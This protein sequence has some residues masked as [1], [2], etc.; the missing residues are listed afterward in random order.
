MKRNNTIYRF[1]GTL[2]LAGAV[3]VG[4][5]KATDTL[6]PQSVQKAESEKAGEESQVTTETPAAEGAFT[7][8][9]SADML[10]TKA[11]TDLGQTL[12]S[13]WE[14]G[15]SVSVYNMT[16]EQAIEG[17]LY[18]QADGTSSTF[19]G[20]VSGN[21]NQGDELF[22]EFLE[23][24]Y[25]IQD[26]TLE[27]LAGQS[28]WAVATVK[29]T[30]IDPE[31]KTIAT[32]K[33]AFEKRQAVVKFNITNR[34]NPVEPVKVTTFYAY[35]GIP[36]GDKF[37]I[38]VSPKVASDELYVAIPNYDKMPVTFEA[39]GEDG[40]DYR[41]IVP[42]VNFEDGLYYRR[43]LQMKRRALVKAPVAKTGLKFN[44][45][46]Q[47]LVDAAHVY[48]ISNEQEV[49]LDHE[50]D[51]QQDSCVISYFVKKEETAETVP[52]AP[53]A[54]ENGWLPS[55]PTQM[56]AGT[57]YIWTKMTGNYD[58]EDADV[59]DEP[60]K[61]VLA[62]A[63]AT[64]SATAVSTEM[65]YSG[66]SQN[67]LSAGAKLMM[68][69]NDITSTKDGDNQ[70]PIIKYYV[71]TENLS[72]APAA[73]NSSWGTS[74]AAVHAGTH[75]VWIMTEGNGDINAVSTK[76][77]K[78]IKKATATLTVT[79]NSSTLT[80]NGSNQNLLSGAATLKIGSTNVTSA[81]DAQSKACSIQYYVSTSST[82][83][84]GGSW[85]T[86]SYSA[87]NAGTYYVW[88][89][90]TGN[91]DINDIA[92][93]YKVSKGI[94][95]KNPTFS[96]ASSSVTFGQSDA[97]NSTKTVNITYDGD[98]TLSASSNDAT[99][100]TASISN[101]VLTIT[102]KSGDA[103]TVTITVT[104]A[105][106]A[107]YNA[108]TGK[109]VTVTL[110]ANDTGVALNSALVGYKVASNGKAYA[111][112]ATIPTGY[113]L[114]GVIVKLGVV[115]KAKDQGTMYNREN[116]R[117]EDKHSWAET[118]YDYYIN[119]LNDNATQ[120]NWILGSRQDYQSIFGGDSVNI[121]SIQN[122]L[123]AAGANPLTVGGVGYGV[124]CFKEDKR[125]IVTGDN[126]VDFYDWSGSTAS[127]VRYVRLIFT[128]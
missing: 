23:P 20:T 25:G 81:T 87:K 39:E 117:V 22:L 4:C 17:W 120:K 19:S 43:T 98:G 16:T 29:V 77:S 100:A 66:S 45:T 95:K 107:N 48:W 3:L 85:G 10:A 114:E 86:T 123:T 109:T 57:Y 127:V 18:A 75:Y 96:L 61:V 14:K 24:Q 65:T 116:C 64:L 105:A 27:G 5:S 76:V 103:G 82:S 128:Y 111:P 58:Y 1:A 44:G 115:M 89:K 2:L 91:G 122:M 51:Y 108:A 11:L 60:V 36:G 118:G 46:A 125:F 90:V 40:F 47:H 88:V 50:K 74:Y 42:D 41:L 21:F 8:T 124:W 73:N 84:T 94:A 28:D 92:Q 99:K 106:G 9:V 7:L 12:G 97:V 93:A 59:S 63:D 70:A 78:Q 119:S 71:T 54:T 35:G 69:E 80:Y 32:N 49:I 13:S 67:L 126:C 72:Q 52:T 68:G 79:A 30:A 6:K 55:V 113:T 33:A 110:T 15:D 37:S 104:P 56:H 53:T 101:K 102:R 26:G 38:K 62:K 83:T 34:K 121:T 31:A 112:T